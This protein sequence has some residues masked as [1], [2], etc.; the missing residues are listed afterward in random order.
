MTVSDRPLND[1][2]VDAESMEDARHHIVEGHPVYTPTEMMGA[3]YE[4]DDD[5][6]PAKAEGTIDRTDDGAAPQEAASP[7]APQTELSSPDRD[8]IARWH[9]LFA[10]R[11]AQVVQLRALLHCTVR[12]K[13]R[14]A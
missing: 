14:D 1:S 7:G 11:F 12:L 10:H 6:P 8:G 9:R 13:L 5:S 2:G 3:V 4:L